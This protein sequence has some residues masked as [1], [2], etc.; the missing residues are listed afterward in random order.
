MW[1]FTVDRSSAGRRID[2]ILRDR[3]PE[4]PYSRIQRLFR[5]DR[6]LVDGDRVGPQHRVA[7]GAVV[8]VES[9]ALAEVVANYERS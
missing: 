1:Q 8:V 6:V 2:R 3:R 7:A 9:G 4:L 5:E